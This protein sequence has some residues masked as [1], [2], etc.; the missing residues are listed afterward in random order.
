MLMNTKTKLEMST[1]D[2]DYDWEN[3]QCLNLYQNSVYSIVLNSV[4][5]NKYDVEI[6]NPPSRKEYE[7]NPKY[8]TPLNLSIDFLKICTLQ[9]GF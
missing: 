5:C 9:G 7:E 8:E 2:M 4:R 1:L 3:K 6:K